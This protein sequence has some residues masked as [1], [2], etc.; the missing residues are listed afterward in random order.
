MKFVTRKKRKGFFK[1]II[2]LLLLSL[3]AFF[4]TRYSLIYG[5]GSDPRYT[6]IVSQSIIENGTIQLNTY[7]NDRIWG[8]TANFDAD[9]NILEYNGR[10]YNYFPLGPSLL[11]VPA[12]LITKAVGWDM[13]L[14]QDNI[15]AQRLLSSF[16]IVLLLWIVYFTTRLLLNPRDSLVITAVSLFGSTLISTLSVALWSV[17]F[18]VIFIGLALWLILR[19][20][21]GKSD[22]VHPAAL[23]MLLFLAF[24]CR[25]AS[26]AFILPVFLYLLFK[27][28]RQMMQTAVSAAIPLA[29]FLLYSQYEF[30][31]WLPIYYSV[32]RFQVQRTPL[33]LALAG[34]LVSPSRGIFVFVPTLILLIPA[35][36]WQRRHLRK[37]PL[38]WLCLSWIGLQLFIAS[39]AAIWWGGHSFGPRILTEL[40]LA[41][42]LLTALVWQQGRAHLAVHSQKLWQMGYLLLGITAVYIHSYQGLYNYSVAVWNVAITEHAAPPLTSPY[43]DLFNWRIPQFLA[44]NE[45]LCQLEETR[46]RDA[47]AQAPL[48]VPYSWGTA[49]RYDADKQVEMAATAAWLREES[50]SLPT[51]QALFL[52]WELIDNNRAPHRAAACDK[53]H[54]LFAVDELPTEPIQLTI[55]TATFGEQT[56]VFFLND[57]PIGEWTFQQQPKL[58]T[59]TA[60]FTIDPQYFRP[61]LLNDLT[62][63]LPNAR[64]AGYRDPTRLSLAIADITLSQVAAD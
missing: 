4:L 35:L 17:N 38:I 36:F 8:A 31:S 37:R 40:M 60:V 34:H 47:L 10:Y 54:I 42:T 58:A 3:V 22:T 29:L 5:A 9:L 49:L 23:G 15:N 52:G 18:S 43:G 20:E 39:R 6:L 27:N 25:A 21:V 12:V 11:S 28:W 59:E 41:F 1:E 63:Q 7:Q 62:I 33:W 19:Y 26:A 13:R 32:A 55:N 53:L 2:P 46:T 44:S 16:S 14:A 61:N 48:L 57:Q 56:A 24:F 51:T 64:R 30:G 45:M 50:E